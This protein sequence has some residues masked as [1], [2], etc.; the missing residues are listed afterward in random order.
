MV[1]QWKYVSVSV[2]Y[3]RPAVLLDQ[4]SRTEVFRAI[5]VSRKG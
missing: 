1:S 4:F 2:Q 5:Q 3:S